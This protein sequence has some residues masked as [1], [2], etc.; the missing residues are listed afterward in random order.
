MCLCFHIGVDA[1]FED[2]LTSEGED[3]ALSK[4]NII[5]VYKGPVNHHESHNRHE[6]Q[7]SSD[8][9]VQPGRP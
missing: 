8:E 1:Y 3:P 6:K 9:I 4:I 5:V 2:Q 7:G